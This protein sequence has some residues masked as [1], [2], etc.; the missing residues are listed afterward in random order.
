LVAGEAL[1][2]RALERLVAPV[3]IAQVARQLAM[4][5]Y[6]CR[7]KLMRLRRSDEHGARTI[8][9]IEKEDQGPRTDG[10]PARPHWVVNLARLERAHPSFFRPRAIVEPEDLE[11]IHEALGGLRRD[12]NRLGAALREARARIVS[13]EGSRASSERSEL[14]KPAEPLRLVPRVR[15]G[16]NPPGRRD[17]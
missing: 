12:V 8:D 15:A 2:S 10:T 17:S 3:T 14:P 5:Y 13:L 16:G 1:V 6:L 9:W 4:P 11:A 7:R